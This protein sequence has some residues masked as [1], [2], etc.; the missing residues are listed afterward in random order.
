MIYNGEKIVFGK[1]ENILMDWFF[2]PRISFQM[3]VEI[4]N[5]AVFV[6][7]FL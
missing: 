6:L 4:F 1:I 2:I 7:P 3:V 5:Q